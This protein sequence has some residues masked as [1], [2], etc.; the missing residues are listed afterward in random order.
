MS[1]IPTSIPNLDVSYTDTNDNK[2][3]R[4]NNNIDIKNFSDRNSIKGFTPET[5]EEFLE[6]LR[7][8][9]VHLCRL[10]YFGDDR[11]GFAFFTYSNQKYELAMYP[12]GQFSG[13]PE[14]AFITSA[15]VYLNE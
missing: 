8:T 15:M 3:T 11:W 2:R 1:A 9:P 7:N 10:R 14:E 6:R 5:R 12:S 13:T 4:N